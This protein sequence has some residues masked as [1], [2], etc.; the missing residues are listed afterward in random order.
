MLLLLG[1]LSCELDAP[2]AIPTLLPE[3]EPQTGVVHTPTLTQASAVVSKENSAHTDQ[4]SPVSHTRDVLPA[5]TLYDECNDVKHCQGIYG[6]AGDPVLIY[7]KVVR[8]N[9]RMLF[10][11]SPETLRSLNDWDRKDPEDRLALIRTPEIKY[12]LAA[13]D[14]Q[15][16]CDP[17]GE[18]GYGGGIRFSTNESGRINLARSTRIAPPAVD[19]AWMEHVD[20]G[21]RIVVRGVYITNLFNPYI[22]VLYGC[23][24]VEP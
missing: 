4:S 12:A 5:R 10:V 16:A 19:R 3:T 21:D 24:I 1:L 17:S 22:P 20:R 6:D 8:K 2:A 7:G 13:R 11:S 14:G 23:D 9:P 15:V 18:G